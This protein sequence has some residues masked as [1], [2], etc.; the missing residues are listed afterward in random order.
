MTKNVKLYQDDDVT[1]WG[2][3]ALR[4]LRPCTHATMAEYV[5]HPLFKIP[6]D[7]DAPGALIRGVLTHRWLAY[8]LLSLIDPSTWAPDD[9]YFDYVDVIEGEPLPVDKLWTTV[10]RLLYRLNYHGYAAAWG[11]VNRL[12]V[13]YIIPGGRVD[14]VLGLSKGL[15]IVIDYKCGKA[16]PTY[17]DQVRRYMRHFDRGG[18]KVSGFIFASEGVPWTCVDAWQWDPW[19]EDC[20]RMPPHLSRNDIWPAAGA[21]RPR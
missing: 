21:R 6:E 20:P 7:A 16:Y 4:G 3:P 15:S 19:M 18:H 9:Y 17:R 14:L 1:L 11:P 2:H 12:G 8:H 5:Q 10:L 13:E